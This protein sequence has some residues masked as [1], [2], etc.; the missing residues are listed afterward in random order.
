MKEVVIV[1][2]NRTAVGKAKKGSLKDF[3]P[4]DMAAE[5]IKD[6][7]KR[8]PQ[9]APEMIDDLIYGCAMPEGEQGMNIARIIGVLA[10]LPVDVPAMTI[11]RFC[12]SGLQSIALAAEKIMCGFA[13]VIIA[14][15]TESMTM[16]PMMGNKIAPNAKLMEVYPKF[17]LPMGLTAEIVAEKYGVSRQ[18]Q[19]EFSARSHHNAANAIKSGNF[20]E[21]ICPLTVETDSYDAK[22]KR[23]TKTFVFD[24]DEGVR[25][26][27][28]AEGLSKLKAAFKVNGTITAGNSSQMSD[29]A[30]SVLVMS[31]DKA[32]E[33]GLKPMARFVSFA[34]HG[35]APEE[36]GIGPVKAIPKA[37]KFAGLKLSDIDLFE[38]NEAFAA[39]ALAV[40]KNLEIDINKVNVNGGAIALGHPLGCTGSKL[41]ASLLYEMKRRGSKYGIV[42]MCIGSGQGAA[43]IFE[44]LS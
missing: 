9:L 6:L 28:S 25:A 11:N 33:L 21:E 34:T 27:T 17:Y 22:G 13:D 31:R 19:D 29:G 30:S 44:N 5:T 40:V 8:V 42:S 23:S 10:G 7:L 24:T 4:D 26:D 18:E 36:M 39:Q 16:V 3:R 20:K 14:G 41:T 2:A 35:V 1:A 43:G 38:L 32:N 37:L 15:G 12:S